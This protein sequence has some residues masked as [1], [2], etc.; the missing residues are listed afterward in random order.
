MNNEN[1]DP[2]NFTNYALESLYDTVDDLRFYNNHDADLIYEHLQRNLRAIP[3]CDHLKRYVY[4][5]AGMSGN[6]DDIPL[7]EYRAVIKESFKDNDTPPSF[8]PTTARF[9]SLIKNWLTQHTVSRKVVFL[10]G[11]GLKMSVEDVNAFL[12]KA[13]REQEMN[14]KNPFEVICWYCYRNRLGYPKFER[15]WRMYCENTPAMLDM[16][17]IY[18]EQTVGIRSDLM[19]V[20]DEAALIAHLSKFKNSENK[21]RFSVTARMWFERLFA[22]TRELAAQI[23]NLAEE[24][25]HSLLADR[26]RA[27]LAKNTR[28][29]DFEKAERLRKMIDGKKVYTA[30]DITESD[31][32][33]IIYAAVPTDRHGNLSPSKASK[34]NDLFM[35]RR[36]SRQRMNNI[37]TSDESGAEID[38]FDLITLNFFIHSQKV[39]DEPNS[40]RRYTEFL[41]STNKILNECSMG[42]LYIANPYECFLLMCMLSDDPLGTYADVWEMSYR[43]SETDYTP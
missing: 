35:G 39:D 1:N 29:F 42:E 9:G 13:L 17:L 4:Q 40:K 41:D 2:L 24:G 27:E 28:L 31:I 14:P 23:Y 34:L 15:L 37:L 22:E 18:S 30:D 8:T 10:L 12:V 19:S 32:E 38:R 11:F 7:D 16:S 36:F 6:Y 5:K 21:A 43:S 3:F 20:H 33:H 25:D 26:Y